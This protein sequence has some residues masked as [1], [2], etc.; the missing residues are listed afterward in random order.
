MAEREHP[1]VDDHALRAALSGWRR[2]ED[3]LYLAALGGADVYQRS[4][5]LVRRT[6]EHLRTLGPGHAALLEASSRG[7]GL[8]GEALSPEPAGEAGVD[9]RLVADAALALR[10]RELLAD[11]AAQRRLDR[12]RAAQEHGDIWVVLETS[13]D[14][15][16]DPLRPYR[17]LEAAVGTG[18]ALL[19]TSAPD[20]DFA[21]SVHAV[22]AVRVDLRTG[23]LQ[24][25]DDARTAATTH[26][27]AAAREHQACV[28][29]GQLGGPW[30]PCA[31]DGS[32][33]LW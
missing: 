33:S 5:D 25:L 15:E 24:E 20:A 28:L 12:L 23:A 6:V 11:Q 26:T 13:G 19:V 2:G 1:D 14:P 3:Q 27:T 30:G 22:E 16:G 18:S 9:L 7:A 10:S 8:V 17:R 21:G 4:L 29:R 32:H 31:R